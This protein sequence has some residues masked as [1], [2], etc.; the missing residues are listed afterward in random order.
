MEKKEP[1]QYLFWRRDAGYY[2]NIVFQIYV[3]MGEPVWINFPDLGFYCHANRTLN[4]LAK[5]DDV[6]IFSVSI[7]VYTSENSVKGVVNDALK[8]AVSKAYPSNPDVI[9]VRELRPNNDPREIIITLTRRCGQKTTAEV[10][11]QGNR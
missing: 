5:G 8:E 10:N 9:G 2:S 6:A 7:I 1:N 4:P 3:F 11:N